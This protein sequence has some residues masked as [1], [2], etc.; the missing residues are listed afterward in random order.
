MTAFYGEL[1]WRVSC[2]YLLLGLGTFLVYG[3]DKISAASGGWRVREDTLHLLDILG[4]WPG[5]FVA[6][7]FFRHKIRKKS[8]RA[9][10][11]ATVILNCAVLGWLLSPYGAQWA[12]EN[13]GGF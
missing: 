1:L 13:F 8:F 10:Y 7:R 11:W 2:Y 5:A 12:Y 9:R 6:Q 4:G 3:I